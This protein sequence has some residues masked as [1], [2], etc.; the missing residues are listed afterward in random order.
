GHQSKEDVERSDKPVLVR[1]ATE[2]EAEL[3]G[4][5]PNTPEDLFRYRAVIVDDVEA[6]FFSADQMS[7]L[8]RF[9]S[10][11][12]GGFLMLGGAESFSDG[13]FARTAI[14]EMLPVYLAAKVSEP[15]DALHWSLT[16]EGWL[17]PWIR[18]RTSEAEERKRLSGQAHFDVLNRGGGVKP[19]ASVLAVVNDG[20]KDHPALVTQRFGRGRT[21]AMLVG[22]FWQGGLGDEQGQKDLGRS[23]RQ[24][25]RWLVADVPGLTE[26]RAEPR[27]D[28]QSVKLEVRARTPA[29]EPVENATVTVKIQRAGA[30]G[31]DAM[32]DL[33]AEASTTEPGLYTA[34]YFPRESGGYRVTASVTNDSGAGAGTAETGWSTNMDGSEFRALV[35]NRALMD[36][37]AKRTGGEVVSPDRLEALVRKMPERRA[38]VNETVTE[39]LWHTP[40]VF[41]IALAFFL[42]EWGLR[43]KFGLA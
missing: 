12:G 20:Q 40:W 30:T 29:F 38:P 41:L 9:V 35:P 14:G 15:A 4:G 5:F 24:I 28:G 1:L 3:I 8:Q 22:D 10:E 7:L 33:P 18:L 16:R 36:D 2:N 21:G 27:T 31:P 19:A 34:E 17:Q 6:E 37:I 39:P 42:G 13:K 23:W 25:L 26:V 11:R 32:I 43:R